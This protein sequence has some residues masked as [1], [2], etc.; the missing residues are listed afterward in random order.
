[1]RT[2]G[3][4]SGEALG[5][6]FTLIELLVVVAIISILAAIAIPNLQRASIRAK[7][8]RC[9]AEM[10]SLAT[11]LEAY[12]VDCN[13]YPPPRAEGYTGDWLYPRHRRLWRLT[14]PIAFISTVPN[15]LF[16]PYTAAYD[17]TDRKSYGGCMELVNKPEHWQ[18]R[19]YS[20]GPDKSDLDAQVVIGEDYQ[21]IDYDP[22]NG[23]ISAGNVF[24][25]G[26]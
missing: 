22:T 14:T 23:T 1:M 19:L 15:D 21:M 17:Y 4:L 26:P 10:R 25:F 20:C 9:Q 3:P 16:R 12:R 7:V 11:A 8:S 18:W 6:G 24:R 5:R 2:T 13:R